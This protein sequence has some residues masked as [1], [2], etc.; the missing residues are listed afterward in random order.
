[1]IVSEA[2]RGV[3][4]SNG[5]CWS[6]D[7]CSS[8]TTPFNPL[9][10]DDLITLS[11]TGS[12]ARSPPAG[13]SHDTSSG[14]LT[15]SSSRD[16]YSAD[17]DDEDDER[18]RDNV[19]SGSGDGDSDSDKG[20]GWDKKDEDLIDNESKSKSS[21][22]STI[23][24]FDPWPT[25]ITLSFPTPTL[26]PPSYH[27]PSVINS[28]HYQSTTEDFSQILH[29]FKPIPP[30]DTISVGMIE[31]SYRPKASRPTVRPAI[32]DVPKPSKPHGRDP[33]GS[34]APKSTLPTPTY[35]APDRTALLIGLIAVLIIVVVVI[36]PLFL[37]VR[38]KYKSS[39]Q[40]NGP[41]LLNGVGKSGAPNGYQFVPVPGANGTLMT[42]DGRQVV[43]VRHVPPAPIQHVNVS[44]LDPVRAVGLGTCGPPTLKRKKDEWYV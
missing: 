6:H 26:H 13:S 38:I 15:P 22:S 8:L 10:T 3:I 1:M 42:V 44:A 16:P 32:I 25:S 30:D 12:S 39:L 29:T 43:S 11:V 33:K 20:N 28:Y 36:A 35:A 14:S 21:G 19:D 41:A 5:V 37:Y 24:P 40:M 34:I 31:Q 17:C 4:N 2:A 9:G 27:H 23:R 7:D 18:C